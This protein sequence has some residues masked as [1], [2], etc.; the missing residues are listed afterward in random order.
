MYDKAKMLIKLESSYLKNIFKNIF[1]KCSFSISL[2]HPEILIRRKWLYKH[3][4]HIP[5]VLKWF[6]KPTW[7]HQFKAFLILNP[8]QWKCNVLRFLFCLRVPRKRSHSESNH[9][10]SGRGEIST[11]AVQTQKLTWTLTDICGSIFK[12]GK[13]EER[14]GEKKEEEC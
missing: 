8:N 12:E 10:Q 9:A 3:G 11:A 13:A 2:I 6:S 5:L 4:N 14:K 7:T 1:Q